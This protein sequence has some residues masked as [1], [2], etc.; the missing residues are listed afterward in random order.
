[1]KTRPK[2]NKI[3]SCCKKDLTNEEIESFI[4]VGKYFF[5]NEDRAS[6]Y[7]R[8]K[9]EEFDNQRA[10]EPGCR[11]LGPSASENPSGP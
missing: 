1:M 9:D 5:C 7:A 2:A 8:R 10:P 3:C 4:Q 6:E 11:S